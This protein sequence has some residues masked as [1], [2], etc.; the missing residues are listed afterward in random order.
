MNQL[1]SRRQ[2]RKDE[3]RKIKTA[4]KP[5]KFAS[6]QY[7]T[8]NYHQE[9]ATDGS[10]KTWRTP[11]SLERQI[12]LYSQ[13]QTQPYKRLGATLLR[14]AYCRYFVDEAKKDTYLWW[15]KDEWK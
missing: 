6:I 14:D 9:I 12:P 15:H 8:H 7:T 5:V 2:W 10:V 13:E 1:K 11:V 3:F 4:E